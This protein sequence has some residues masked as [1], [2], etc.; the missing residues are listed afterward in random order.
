MPTVKGSNKAMAMEG[1]MP[2][3]APP[4]IP[5]KTPAKADKIIQPEARLESAI[6][7]LSMIY[8]PIH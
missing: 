2:G 4:K 3:K 7:K 6:K 5:H 8:F 1:E